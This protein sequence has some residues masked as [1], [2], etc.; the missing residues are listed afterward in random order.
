DEYISEHVRGWMG[1]LRD[2]C[3]IPSVSARHEAIEPCAEL[4]ARM[5]E[6][7]GFA[8]EITPTADG[9]HPIVLGHAA[10]AKRSRKLLFYNHYDVQPPEPLELWDSPP[11]Q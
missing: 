6:R 1:E 5:L 2:L 3:A 8:T 10:G 4:V 7:R 11:F 9:G